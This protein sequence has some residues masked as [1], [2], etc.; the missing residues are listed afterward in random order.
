MASLYRWLL[1]LYPAAYRCEYGEEM[2]GVYREAR[3]ERN[4]A[5][6]LQR[7]AFFLREIAGLLSGALQER[8]WAMADFNCSTPISQRRFTMR[9]GFRFPKS[10]AVLMAVILAGTIL[11]IEKAESIV[12]S[13]AEPDYPDLLGGVVAIF[14]A[15]FVLAVVAWA[16]LFALRRS[17]A[18]RLAEIPPQNLPRAVEK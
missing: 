18:H 16:A 12:R 10:T 9:P 11:A 14:A 5:T 3:K 2:I 6:A 8:W 7:S 17:G 1:Y 4:K 15:A 13:A